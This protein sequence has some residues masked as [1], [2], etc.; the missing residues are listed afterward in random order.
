MAGPRSVLLLLIGLF[1]IGMCLGFAVTW[2]PLTA[3]RG[4][5]LWAV[6]LLLVGAGA[7]AKCVAYALRDHSSPHGR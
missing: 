5:G 4:S 1:G 2:V 6:P 7:G 3:A